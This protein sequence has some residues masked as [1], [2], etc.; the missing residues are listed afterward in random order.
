MIWVHLLGALV[1]AIAHQSST[2]EVH[3][4]YVAVGSGSADQPSAWILLPS[5]SLRHTSCS[6][7]VQEAL[8][9]D[10]MARVSNDMLHDA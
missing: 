4:S 8:V 9:A 2:V 7:A 10:S 6:G 3:S 1:G 5:V